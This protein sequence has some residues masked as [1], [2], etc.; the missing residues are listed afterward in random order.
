[1]KLCRVCGKEARAIFNIELKPIPICESCANSI[2]W[3]QTESLI[4]ESNA[5]ILY[6]EVTGFL[7]TK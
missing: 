4:R 3:Q 6:E 1:M 5:R 7:P 2:T